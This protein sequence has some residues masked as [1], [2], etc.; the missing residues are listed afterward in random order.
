MPFGFNR[1][2]FDNIKLRKKFS[3]RG[4]I[5]ENQMKGVPTPRALNLIDIFEDDLEVLLRLSMP[6]PQHPV[7]K[8]ACPNSCF[9][10]YPHMYSKM[11]GQL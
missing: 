8:H 6:D 9:L 7:M 1:I 10:A 3:I 2:P 4:N 5:N 11:S